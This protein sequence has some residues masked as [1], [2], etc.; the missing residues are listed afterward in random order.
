MENPSKPWKIH[1]NHGKCIKTMGNASKA[2]EMHQKH[3]KCIKTMGN[4]SKSWEMHQNHGKCIKSME[5]PSKA[6]KSMENS[7]K[8][9][10]SPSNVFNC[11]IVGEQKV[12]HFFLTSLSRRLSLNLQRAPWRCLVESALSLN[13]VATWLSECAF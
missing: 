13:Q 6:W 1:Q 9:M 10:E 4:A 11:V 8:T 12:R 5:N 3:G 7:I 2:W